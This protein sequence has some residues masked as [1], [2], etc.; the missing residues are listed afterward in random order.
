MDLRDRRQCKQPP[1]L[2][3]IRGPRATR[4]NCDASKSGLKGTAMANLFRSPSLNQI[5]PASGKPHESRSAR[6]GI[7]PMKN[8]LGRIE[9]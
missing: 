3:C 5:I 9:L 4:R 1:Y 8:Y 7:S 6:V 2:I